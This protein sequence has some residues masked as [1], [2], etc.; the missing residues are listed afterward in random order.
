[1]TAL[2]DGLGPNGK[3]VVVGAYARMTSDK[4]ESRVVST[5]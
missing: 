2:F 1:M 5:M 3:V 4:A